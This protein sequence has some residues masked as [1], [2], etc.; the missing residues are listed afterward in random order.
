MKNAK[1]FPATA[2]LGPVVAALLATV[3]GCDDDYEL[4]YDR[5]YIVP[6]RSEYYYAPYA[7]PAYT[8]YDYSYRSAVVGSY[9][10]TPYVSY[11]RGCYRPGP[12]HGRIGRGFRTP[13]H[14][15]PRIARRGRGR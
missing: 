7:P 13:V 12:R 9:Y 14:R 1:R 15:S 2:A 3:A 4:G 8:V 10:Y 11:R 5:T 6:T